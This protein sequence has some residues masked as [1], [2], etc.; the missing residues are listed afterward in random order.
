MKITDGIKESVR[1]VGYLFSVQLQMGVKGVIYQF[2]YSI[3]NSSKSFFL[4]LLPKIAIDFCT[5]G[6]L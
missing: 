5:G 1:N 6:N 2:L 4:I 3:L